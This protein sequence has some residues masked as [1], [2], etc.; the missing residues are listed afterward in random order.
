MGSGYVWYQAGRVRHGGQLDHRLGA[1]LKGGQHFGIHVLTCRFFPA[2]FGRRI[3]VYR[4]VLAF[5]KTHHLKAQ[6]A[7]E[8][9]QHLANT[10][11]ISHCHRVNATHFLR[12][13]VQKNADRN[14]R[15]DVEHNNVLL[16]QDT[17]PG[18]LCADLGHAGGFDHDVQAFQLG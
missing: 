7:R 12:Q 2:R 1:I 16:V 5:P 3:V 6:R 9:V 13:L 11:F 15:L 4:V 10:R 8:V 17:V 14:V 18:D